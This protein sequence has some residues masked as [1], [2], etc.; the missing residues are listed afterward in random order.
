MNELTII[1][2]IQA[3]LIVA[4]LIGAGM[5]RCLVK[6]KQRLASIEDVLGI[7][8]PIDDTTRFIHR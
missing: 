3:T 6:I 7:K 5:W 1:L 8:P 4:V 2:A